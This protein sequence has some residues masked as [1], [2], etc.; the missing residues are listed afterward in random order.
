MAHAG[1]AGDASLVEIVTIEATWR[2]TCS[3]GP[4]SAVHCVL[5]SE[6]LVEFLKDVLVHSILIN[7]V[8]QTRLVSCV[9]CPGSKDG[10]LVGGEE[11]AIGASRHALQ[12]LLRAH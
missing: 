12:P 2:F 1:L 5:Q 3:D 7:E 6:L 4:V 10:L 11:A 8:L 9:S